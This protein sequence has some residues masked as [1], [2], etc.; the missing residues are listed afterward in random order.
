MSSSYKYLGFC[1]LGFLTIVF[2]VCEILSQKI[3]CWSIAFAL[4]YFWLSGFFLCCYGWL[5]HKEISLRIWLFDRPV[6]FFWLAVLIA[7]A[8]IGYFDL[9]YLFFPSDNL[10]FKEWDNILVES[11]GLL[12]DIFLFGIGIAIYDEIRGNKLNTKRYS[13]ELEDYRGWKDS[14]AAF[15]VAG[16]VKR[17]EQE[18]TGD[19]NLNNLHIGRLPLEK[20]LECLT[21]N[22]D[23]ASLSDSDFFGHDL[24]GLSFRPRI[25]HNGINLRKSK[26]HETKFQD[27]V[28]DCS[29]LSGAQVHKTDFCHASMERAIFTKAEFSGALF[30]ST[31]LTGANLNYATFTN[32]SFRTTVLSGASLIG[33]KFLEDCA[34]RNVILT[35][36]RVD[37]M[38]WNNYMEPVVEINSRYSLVE[39]PFPD[40]DGG[41]HDY[42]IIGKPFNI[43]IN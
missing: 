27:V 2:A 40:E 11:H 37:A 17:L 3:C 8:V 42:Y 20:R 14:E 26:L 4:F 12:F 33:T 13:E 18:S 19:I 6:R 31:V 38:T 15:R 36:A 23:Y 5:N 16:I 35:G 34:F 7:I 41:D 9:L 24:S 1:I 25:E 21:T 43:L 30:H 39:G 22:V 32:C 29:F 28:M 10:D